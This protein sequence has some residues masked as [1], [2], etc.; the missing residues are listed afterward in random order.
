MSFWWH[1]VVFQYREKVA[2]A[3]HRQETVDC[4]KK[5]NAR[6]K[7]KVSALD[8]IPFESVEFTYHKNELNHFHFMLAGR[9]FDDDVGYEELL[10]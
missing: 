2:S 4:L 10:Q 9:H 1:R 8:T 5:F 3:V 7:L 6:R